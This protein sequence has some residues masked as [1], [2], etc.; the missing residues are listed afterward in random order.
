L[1]DHN[2]TRRGTTINKDVLSSCCLIRRNRMSRPGVRHGHSQVKY[3]CSNSARGK[4]PRRKSIAR[5]VQHFPLQPWSRS[6]TLRL[7]SVMMIIDNC[8]LHRRHQRVPPDGNAHFYYP[9]SLFSCQRTVRP[10]F[11]GYNSCRGLYP[12]DMHCGIQNL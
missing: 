1:R 6:C 9:S 10:K 8:Q 4:S 12:T 7:R 3:N 5:L 2:C 11:T